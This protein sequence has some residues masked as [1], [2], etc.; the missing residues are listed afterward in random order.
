M[1]GSSAQPDHQ[2]VDNTVLFEM[3]EF[4]AIFKP[5]GFELAALIQE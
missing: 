2:I 1:F 5:L 3:S 4:L